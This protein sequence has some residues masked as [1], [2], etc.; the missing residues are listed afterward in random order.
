MKVQNLNV[1]TVKLK[2]IQIFWLK[3]NHMLLLLL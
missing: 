3:I 2:Q 1:F